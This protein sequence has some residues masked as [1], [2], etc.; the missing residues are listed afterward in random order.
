MVR[1]IAARW[2][3]TLTSVL[4]LGWHREGCACRSDDLLSLEAD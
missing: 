2:L 3:I 1:S 4:T